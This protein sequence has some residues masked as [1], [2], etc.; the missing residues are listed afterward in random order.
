MKLVSSKTATA[1]RKATT[2][3]PQIEIIDPVVEEHQTLL[4]YGKAG[5]GKTTLAS[6]MDGPVLF[7]DT[8]ETG[9]QSIIGTGV[10]VAPARS[11]EDFIKIKDYIED[12]TTFKTIVVDTLT[13][14]QDLRIRQET[15]KKMSLTYGGLTRQQFGKIAGDLKNVIYDFKE[16]TD[17][18]CTNKK[19][20]V[21][22][23]HMRTFNVDEGEDDELVPEINA[24][25]MPSICKTINGIS[26]IIGNTFITM[27]EVR[28]KEK[29]GNRV[30][31][32]TKR[33]YQFCVRLGPSPVYTTKM[34][35]PKGR[36]IPPYLIDPTWA[37]IKAL[38]KG[39]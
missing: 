33:V 36:A 27:K 22:L 20:I 3:K 37:M 17:S 31:S 32:K 39:E 2:T 1:K 28:T 30:I 24:L 14:L 5:T 8:N 34:R 18:N 11:W 16:L 25:L 15:G 26:D 35:V 19:N 4:L 21:Y 7:I 6:T 38:M 9:Y 23:S 10:K 12:D 13:G 29:K